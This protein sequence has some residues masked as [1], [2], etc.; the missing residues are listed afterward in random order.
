MSNISSNINISIN[1]IGTVSS[2]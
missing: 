2:Q 1:N